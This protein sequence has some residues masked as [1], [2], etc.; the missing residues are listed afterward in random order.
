VPVFNPLD[1]STVDTAKP[2]H[3]Q[4]TLWCSTAKQQFNKACNKTNK[5]QQRN[6]NNSIRI[7]LTIT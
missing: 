7:Q 3:T 2:S 4:T 1:T 5:F 6:S